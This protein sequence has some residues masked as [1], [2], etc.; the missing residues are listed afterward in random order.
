MKIH[1]PKVS[2]NQIKKDLDQN[3]LKKTTESNDNNLDF[4]DEIKEASSEVDAIVVLTEWDI[5]SKI[6]WEQISK[7]VRKPCWVF[8]ARSIVDPLKVKKSGLNFWRIGD[9]N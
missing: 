1:D 9:G 2:S 5:Y 7:N 3:H 6:D 8:D 4:C